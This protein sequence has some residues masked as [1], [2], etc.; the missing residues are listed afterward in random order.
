[1]S[2]TESKPISDIPLLLNSVLA[3][4]NALSAKQLT[5]LGISTQ[6]ARALVV[7]LHYSQLR[8]SRLSRLLGLE[9]TALS[10]LLRALA[11]KQLIVRN[12]VANDNRA[13]EVRL[14]E[15]GRRI[16]HACRT[17]TRSY[18]RTLLTGL[19]A[20][21]LLLLQRILVKMNDNIAPLTRRSRD[22]DDQTLA[23]PRPRQRVAKTARVRA[24]G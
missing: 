22:P 8:C 14:S 6:S 16:A 17:A 4:L 23:S 20:D 18:E 12:R 15:K 5:G 19:A 21:E 7:L 9:A 10:H 1:M 3:G 11:R 13:V 2:R 24:A